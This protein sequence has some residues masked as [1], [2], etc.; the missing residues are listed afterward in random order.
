MTNT[1]KIAKAR[2]QSV[3]FL[4][5]LVIAIMALDHVRDY[6]SNVRFDPLDLDQTNAALFLTR[7]I[8]HFCA[9]VFIFLA[10]TSA[11]FQR[12][13]GK[14]GKELSM[15]LL[16]RGIWLVIL[17]L[18]FVKLGWM[19]DVRL[20]VGYH[21]LQVIWAIGISMIAMA[22]L[23]WLPLRAI[24]AIGL[25]MVVGHNLLAPIDATVMA[26][27]AQGGPFPTATT[28]SDGL[29]LFLHMNGAIPVGPTIAFVA[30]P[31]VPWIGVMALGYVFAELYQQV[32]TRRQS[33]LLKLG[34]GTAALFFILRAINL[35]GDP[36]H[37]AIQDDAV[38]TVLSFLNVTKYPPSL[39]FLLMTLAPAFILLSVSENWR[40][41][42]FEVF[43]TFGRVP[44]FFYV[45]HIYAA[46]FAA[47]ILAMAQGNGAASA[48]TFFVFF[49]PEHGVGLL[50]VYLFWIVI[51]VG[52]YFPSRWFAG[53][54]KRSKKWWMSYL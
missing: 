14:Q 24:A 42:A 46:H 36:S 52:L 39:L 49:P 33:L 34:I 28:F 30:Y 10:G 22:V 3:D 7:W 50:G 25:I 21:F 5:G 40:G 53:V 37:W 51:V 47:V 38:K 48:M 12:H 11:G 20:F 43:V 27:L 41:K 8:T 44:L 4:R 29:W 13:A 15:F 9:P 2:I 18:T 16:K 1:A 31:V 45:I 26:G 35:Y 32:D 54:K 19:F 17:E 6:V 23:V